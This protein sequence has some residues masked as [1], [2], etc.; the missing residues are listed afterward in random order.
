MDTAA[1]ERAM[2]RA[3][4]LWALVDAELVAAWLLPLR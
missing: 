3:L 1:H 2:Y 4:V